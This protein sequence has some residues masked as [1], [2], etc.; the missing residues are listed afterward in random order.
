MNSLLYINILFCCI[1]KIVVFIPHFKVNY[2]YFAKQLMSHWHFIHP[3][4]IIQC[5]YLLP[6]W[7]FLGKKLIL[8]LLT[9]LRQYLLAILKE[10][11][12]SFKPTMLEESGKLISGSPGKQCS[13]DPIHTKMAIKKCSIVLSPFLVHILN[14]SLSTGDFPEPFKSTVVTPILNFMSLLTRFKS[15][16]IIKNPWE[17]CCFKY[18]NCEQIVNLHIGGSTRQ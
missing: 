16:Y 9:S 10:N 8:S 11:D 18:I 2:A 6:G 13:L 1:W 15:T 14:N 4:F 3:K 12:F 5:T 17:N 7:V